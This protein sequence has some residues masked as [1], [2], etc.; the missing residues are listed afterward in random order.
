MYRDACIKT[1]AQNG[2]SET[3][4]QKTHGNAQ[5][6]EHQNTR[7]ERNA[8]KHFRVKEKNTK[9]IKDVENTYVIY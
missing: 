8:P 9:D 7:I 4:C 1:P 3:E 2:V 5:K 6:R